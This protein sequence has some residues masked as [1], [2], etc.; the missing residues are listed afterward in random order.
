MAIESRQQRVDRMN[1]DAQAKPGPDGPGPVGRRDARRV[2]VVLSAALLIAAALLV[3][4]FFSNVNYDGTSPAP[5]T[6]RR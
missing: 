3:W 4:M 5:V 6:E 1:R 2:I